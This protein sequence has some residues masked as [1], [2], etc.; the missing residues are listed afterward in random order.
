MGVPNLGLAAQLCSP[1]PVPLV[2]ALIQADVSPGSPSI[3]GPSHQPLGSSCP[4]VSLPLRLGTFLLF[5]SFL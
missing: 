4:H 5:K 1:V 3:P 2:P